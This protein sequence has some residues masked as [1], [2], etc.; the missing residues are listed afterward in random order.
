MLSE[1]T[2]S[3]VQFQSGRTTIAAEQCRPQAKGIYPGLLVVQEWWGLNGHIKEIAARFAGEGYTTLAPDLYSRLGN[4]VT[5][6]P[7]EAQRLMEALDEETALLDLEAALRYLRTLDCVDEDRLGVVGFCMGGSYALRLACWAGVVRAAVPF[8]GQVPE[9][10][11]LQRLACPV[12]Y[13]YG[14]ADPWIPR[15]EVNRLRESLKRSKKRG[16]VVIYPNAPHAFFNDTRRDVYRAE[17]AR[18]AWQRSL[19]FLDTHLRGY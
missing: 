1:V 6:D 18:D 14:D 9:E 19:A 11:V 3:R 8:Y 13:F 12:L 5:N 15:E 10:T 17:A 7:K 4:K 2:S 16:E